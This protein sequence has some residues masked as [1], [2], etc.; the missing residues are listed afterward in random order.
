MS[1][2][3]ARGGRAT[4]LAGLVVAA[5]AAVLTAHGLT[6]V[7]L[8]SKVPTAIAWLYPVITDGL[9]LV[10]YAATTQLSGAS[11]RYAWA[12]VLLSAGL[13]GIAQAVFLAGGVDQAAPQLR[14]GVG[15]WPAIA[16]AIAAHLL[17]LIGQS[18]TIATA[19]PGTEPADQA[20]TGGQRKSGTVVERID[21]DVQ[22]GDVPPA[23]E[24]RQL[25]PPQ[26]DD[27]VE[28]AEGVQDARPGSDQV[29]RVQATRVCTP[30]GVRVERSDGVQPDLGQSPSEDPGVLRTALAP[31]D[32]AFALAQ[33]GLRRAGSLPSVRELVEQAQVSQGTA[34]AVLRELRKQ[35]PGLH[36][37][38][39]ES[40][41]TKAEADR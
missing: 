38:N 28:Q 21:R 9:A 6:E 2:A 19:I 10:A 22:P 40:S 36:L 25:E 39:N 13:S 37:I 17:Y 33:L 31:R 8:G 27:Q 7:A 12:V 30:E 32:R 41:T 20:V 26:S 15:A 34:A 14:F 23:R 4:W 3:P 35:P 1:G 24:P 5:G 11:R 16:A 29:V 18:R